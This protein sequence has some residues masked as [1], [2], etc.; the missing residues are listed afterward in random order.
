MLNFPAKILRPLS[1]PPP[2]PPQ[3]LAPC[4]RPTIW[5]PCPLNG[6]PMFVAQ[7]CKKHFLC[8]ALLANTVYRTVHIFSLHIFIGADKLKEPY[9]IRSSTRLLFFTTE[10][11]NHYR[12]YSNDLFIYIWK[13]SFYRTLK[14]KIFAQC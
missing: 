5:I 12:N 10:R 3:K 8:S 7:C 4:N 14:K 1:P 9:F 11:N 6:M 2:N 13:D